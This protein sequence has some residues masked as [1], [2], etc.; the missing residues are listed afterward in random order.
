MQKKQLQLPICNAVYE[1]IFTGKKIDHLIAVLM[2]HSP[3]EECK[4]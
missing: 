4:Q 2:Q 1:I 3:V